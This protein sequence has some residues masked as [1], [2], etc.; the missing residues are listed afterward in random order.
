MCAA[1]VQRAVRNTPR[2]RL[3]SASAPACLEP[4]ISASGLH[5]RAVLPAENEP[6]VPSRVDGAGGSSDEASS[7]RPP[8]PRAQCVWRHTDYVGYCQIETD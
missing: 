6:E 2:N 5:S 4:C 3:R 8:H 1:T 7:S